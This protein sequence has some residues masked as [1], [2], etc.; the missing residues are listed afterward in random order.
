MAY[1]G[2]FGLLVGY[3]ITLRKLTHTYIYYIKNKKSI[4]KMIPFLHA[5][6]PKFLQWPDTNLSP[7][8]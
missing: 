1:K 2:A 7:T 3:N 5:M 8:M 6:H 4:T